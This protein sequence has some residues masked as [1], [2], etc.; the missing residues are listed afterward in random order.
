M[1]KNADLSGGII[2][3]LQEAFASTEERIASSQAAHV[4]IHAVQLPTLAVQWHNS[5]T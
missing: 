3:E 2:E 1:T 5:V 4:V